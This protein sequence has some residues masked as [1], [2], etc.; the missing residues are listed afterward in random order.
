ML[1]ESVRP[2]QQKYPQKIF[3]LMNVKGVH[4]EEN[5][6]EHFANFGRFRCEHWFGNCQ[7]LLSSGLQHGI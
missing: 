1:L 7:R 5:K 6:K 3:C 2:L 4:D